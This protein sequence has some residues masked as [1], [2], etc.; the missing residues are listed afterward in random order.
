MNTAEYVTNLINTLKSQ[1]VPF[2][3][4]AWEAAK[5]CVGWPYVFGARWNY[6][7][8]ANRRRFY[9]D[10]HPT[11]KTKC[12]NFN[13]S[14]SVDC[15]GCKWYPNSKYTRINDCRGF[16]YGVLYAV[17]GWEL[18]GAGC[19]AQWNNENNWKA[20]GKVSDGIPQNTLVCLFYSKDNKEKT[21]EHT[22]FGFNGETVE[23]SSGVQYF[24]TMNKKWTHWAV[25]KCVEGDVPVPT[26]TPTP[27]TKP[28][29]RRGATGPYVVECQQDLISLGYSCGAKGADGIYGSG[30][31]AAVT[32]FQK[33]KGLTADGVCGKNTWAALDAAV[34]PPA[35]GPV[36]DTYSV[37]ITGL[38]LTQA[39]AI[40]ANYPGNSKIIEED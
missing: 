11:I 3:T 33:A 36:A 17:Y 25:P 37:V 39:Q 6:C 7:T 23:C 10:E 13:G 9:S 5:A 26:P 14:S 27:T 8:P 16:T 35:P 29:L 38:D 21:W 18:I 19:T 15:S 24:S 2:S 31:I 34:K 4:V 32:A 22:G 12:K 30:T 28:T 40:A 1:G 20:K